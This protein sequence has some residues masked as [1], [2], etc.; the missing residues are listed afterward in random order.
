MRL[1][2][3]GLVYLSI[4]SN[5]KEIVIGAIIVLAVALDV[6]RQ[7]QIRWPRRRSRSQS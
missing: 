2:E 5:A 4:P 7:G 6:A 1:V 3:A